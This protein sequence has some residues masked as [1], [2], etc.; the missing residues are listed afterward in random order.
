MS[1][2]TQTSDTQSQQVNQI[3]QWVSNAGQQNYAF[4]QGVA[5]QP[6]TQ[7]QGKMVADTSPQTQQAWDLAASSGNVGQ[8]QYAGAQAGFLNSL[9]QTPGTCTAG[10]LSN[11]N[12]SPYM[13]PYTQNVIDTTLPIMQQN[14]GLS[15]VGNQNAASSANA[16]GGSRMG[17][18]QGVTQAQ[19]AQGMAQMAQQLNAANFGQAQSAAQQD[20]ANRLTASQSNQSA[21]Q[22]K[23]NS[24]ILASQGLANL[25]DSQTKANAANFTMLS[26]A[27][28]GEQGSAQDKINANMAKFTQAANYPQQQ[29][30]TLLSALGMTPH[31]TATTGSSQTQTTT[32][33]NWGA[34]A[35]GGL[36]DLSGFFK[37]GSD[38]RL[39]TDVTKLGKDPKTGL[40][41]HAFRY[42][43][44][45]KTY[46]KVVGPMAQE[47]EKK[48]PGATQTSGRKAHGRSLDHGGVRGQGIRHEERRECP[49]RSPRPTPFRRCS[50]PGEAVLNEQ[51]ATKL[52]RKNITKLNTGH[53]TLFP[54][55][56]RRAGDH[57]SALAGLVHAAQTRL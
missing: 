10:Q 45:P 1:G 6:L 24:D 9:G 53:A 19:G 48:F 57:G 7:Y 8:D 18:Q 41:M 28:A 38:R 30:A 49:A 39:K 44:D 42:K 4:A 32:P 22:A 26:Q 56:R 52:G 46:P 2:T 15:Q 16:F 55:G 43:G 5:A 40:T 54:L 3:P 37:P 11:T 36:E 14:L 50:A 34:L 13:N 12:L 33:T 17:V 35:L 31:D 29:L 20:I 23:I 21:K 47:V 27:G 25:G 51:A